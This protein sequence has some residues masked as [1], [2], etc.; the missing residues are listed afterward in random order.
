MFVSG[1]ISKLRDVVSE[2]IVF[3]KRVG[4]FADYAR[5]NRHLDPGFPGNGKERVPSERIPILI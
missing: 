1:P 3:G 4:V 5:R 2:L